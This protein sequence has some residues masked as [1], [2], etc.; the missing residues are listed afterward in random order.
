[1]D[2]P[3]ILGVALGPLFAVFL[4]GV[5][6]VGIRLAIARYMPDCWLKRQILAERIKSQYSRA[7]SRIAEEAAAHPRGWRHF[8]K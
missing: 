1:M 8:I 2:W 6:G 3:Q 4:F 5:V 7:N